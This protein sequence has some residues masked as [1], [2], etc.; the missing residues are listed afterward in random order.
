MEETSPSLGPV[1]AL[2]CPACGHVLS[3]YTE[4]TA[5]VP[6]RVATRIADAFGSWRFLVVM[7]AA[8]LV[9]ILANVAWHPLHPYP[10][11]MLDGL[12]LGLTVLASVQLPL[13]LLSQRQDVARD[14]ARDR[15]TLRVAA[16]TEADLHA[17]RDPAST[18]ASAPLHAD[19]PTRGTPT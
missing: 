2:T 19:E 5:G 3:M 8:V 15:E 9:W 1:E 18:G 4:P 6:E 17:I 12:G 16:H 14:R 13:I 11:M 10:T 7:S